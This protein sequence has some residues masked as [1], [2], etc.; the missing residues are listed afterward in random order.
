MRIA[1]ITVPGMF[2]HIIC[3]F[4]DRR[5]FVLDDDDRARYL[6]L[7]GR[8]IRDSDWRC[9]AWALMSNHIHLG[10]IAGE[11]PLS[12]WARR[13]H[14]P[15][16]LWMNE[17]HGH[18]GPMFAGRPTAWIIRP[19]NEGR[20][21][22]Y[23]HNNPV[24]AGLVARARDSAWT[25]HRAYLGLSAAPR[26]L[27]VREGLRRADFAGP[28]ELEAFVDGDHTDRNDPSLVAMRRE[29]RGYGA[30]EFGTPWLDPVEVPLLGRP[31]TRLRIQ[32]DEVVRTVARM[33]A[34]SEAALCMPSKQPRIVSARRLAVHCAKAVGVTASEIAAALGVAPQTTSRIGTKPP[35]RRERRQIKRLLADLADARILRIEKASPEG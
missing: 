19:H 8:A 17:R 15:F 29:S 27:A 20:V 2:H 3:R 28:A 4:I 7:F 32:P 16:A 31:F 9:V 14:P 33:T 1:R 6:Q 30:I 22:A 11:Q 10:M 12:A 24:R 34:M 35:D 13:T 25:S 26:W 23:I 21:I 18:L 5:Y